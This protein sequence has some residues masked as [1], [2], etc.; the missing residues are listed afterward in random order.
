MKGRSEPLP[1]G[2]DRGARREE[3][4]RTG[5]GWADRRSEANP[6]TQRRRRWKPA[7][8]A[9]PGSRPAARLRPGWAVASIP[10]AR[11]ACALSLRE[12]AQR[13]SARHEETPV[14]VAVRFQSVR[15]GRARGFLAVLCGYGAMLRRYA[16]W[17]RRRC[18][19][20]VGSKGA[21]GVGEPRRRKHRS[22]RQ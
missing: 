15:E 20:W 1:W 21:G 3:D 19:R 5:L 11:H 12:R 4:W 2:E 18:G 7:G 22:E 6:R 9:E 17:P 16:E 8:E 14:A 10:C 13:A